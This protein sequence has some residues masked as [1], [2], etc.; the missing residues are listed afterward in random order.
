MKMEHDISLTATMNEGWTSKSVWFWYTMNTGSTT[1]YPIVK[2]YI[3]GSFSV[4]ADDVGKIGGVLS[5]LWRH[6]SAIIVREKRDD[7][8]GYIHELEKLVKEHGKP[9]AKVP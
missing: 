5:A 6:D 9:V 2:R 3:Y 7:Y 1:L 4:G 8:S